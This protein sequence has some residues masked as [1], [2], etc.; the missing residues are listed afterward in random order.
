M[1]TSH[2]RRLELFFGKKISEIT[3]EERPAYEAIDRKSIKHSPEE[4]ALLIY[5][6]KKMFGR[7]YFELIVQ[8]NHWRAIFKKIHETKEE[9]FLAWQDLIISES[10]RSLFQE[11]NSEEIQ[12]E[13]NDIN[14]NRNYELNSISEVK[15]YSFFGLF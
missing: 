13:N 14:N 15:I 2:S 6:F 9:R 10:V 12:E 7:L 4:V 3:D 11:E 8:T 5:E 1:F